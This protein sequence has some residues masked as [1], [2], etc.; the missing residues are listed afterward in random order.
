MASSTW[1]CHMHIR[2]L[3]LLFAKIASSFDLSRVRLVTGCAPVSPLLPLTERRLMISSKQHS[4]V[5][6]SK[7]ATSLLSR[8][9]PSRPLSDQLLSHQTW[10]LPDPPTPA[11]VTAAHCTQPFQW[12]SSSSP[13]AEGAEQLD[14]PSSFAEKTGSRAVARMLAC[15]VIKVLQSKKN[16]Y[17]AT[18]RISVGGGLFAS[19]LVGSIV[20]MTEG[21]AATTG[22][23]Q[24]S[25][26]LRWVS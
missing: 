2:A 8:L 18:D 16:V 9:Q 19:V 7:T 23:V 11:D 20:P 26:P 15:Q 1:P 13:S 14:P 4:S 6:W 12:Y 25:P 22:S 21:E 3:D 5:W 24:I 10:T 17:A